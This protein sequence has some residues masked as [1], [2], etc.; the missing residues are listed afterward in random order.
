MLVKGAAAYEAL[1]GVIGLASHARFE[2]HLVTILAVSRAI[3]PQRWPRP[4]VTSFFQNTIVCLGARAR[5]PTLFHN[6]IRTAEPVETY[7]DEPI[8]RNTFD[9]LPRIFTHNESI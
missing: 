7:S 1:A 8:A 4:R 6:M 3:R 5:V 9:I 2:Q